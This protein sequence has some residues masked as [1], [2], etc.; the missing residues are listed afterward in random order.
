[1][2]NIKRNSW[3][4]LNASSPPT[5]W[6]HPGYHEAVASRCAVV[7][8]KYILTNFYEFYLKLYF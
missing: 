5:L 3:K 1:M 7:S 4:K 2:S 8:C 6:V